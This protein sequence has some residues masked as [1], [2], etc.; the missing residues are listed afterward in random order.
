MHI[1]HLLTVFLQFHNDEILR[2]AKI[3]T[4]QT[5]TTI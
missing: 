1:I 2:K 5:T 3:I 4:I